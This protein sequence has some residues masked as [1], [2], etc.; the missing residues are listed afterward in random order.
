MDVS[1]QGKPQRTM[2]MAQQLL[3]RGWG[4]G[5]WLWPRRTHGTRVTQRPLTTPHSGI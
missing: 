5:A 2:R 3:G 4:D 1:V